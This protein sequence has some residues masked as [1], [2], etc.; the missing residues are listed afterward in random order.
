MQ[1]IKFCLKRDGTIVSFEKNRITNAINKAFKEAEEG[2]RIIAQKVTETVVERIIRQFQ[3]EI[4]SVE[5]IQDIVEETL[6]DYKFNKSAKRYILYR[7]ERNR[8]RIGV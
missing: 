5:K 6:M 1:V 2:N 4:P 3:R 8:S 7:E